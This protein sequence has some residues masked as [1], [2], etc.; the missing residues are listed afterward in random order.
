MLADPALSGS[1]I[2]DPGRDVL[3]NVPEVLDAL[4]MLADEA[5]TEDAR[6]AAEG[7]LMAL[8]AQLLS[9][10]QDRTARELDSD[11]LHVMMSYQWAVQKTVKRIVAELQGRGYVVWF[12]VR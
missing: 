11:Q 1:D 7:A 4:R 9:E 5:L 3:Q 10:K 8:D 2:D 6:H 12:D